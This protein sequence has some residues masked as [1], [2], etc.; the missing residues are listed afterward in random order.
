MITGM[1]LAAHTAVGLVSGIGC[2]ASRLLGALGSD[3]GMLR[4][5]LCS[6]SLDGLLLLSPVHTL[7]PRY[8]LL[9]GYAVYIVTHRGLLELLQYCLLPR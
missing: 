4:E 1:Q 9:F 5:Q 2:S 8:S 7:D 3:I 6:A